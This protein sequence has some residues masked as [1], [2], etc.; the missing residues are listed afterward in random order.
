MSGQIVTF[1]LATAGVVLVLCAV[2]HGE[3][4]VRTM[5]RD[6]AA[7]NAEIHEMK[8]TIVSQDDRIIEQQ[9]LLRAAATAMKKDLAHAD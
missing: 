8:V 7:L 3:W 5:N 6:I 1:L 4:Q 9:R 2:V